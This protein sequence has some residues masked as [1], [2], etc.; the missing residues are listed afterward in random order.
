MPLKGK[1]YKMKERDLKKELK[2]A[3]KAKDA[4]K[5]DAIRMILGEVPRLNKKK[6]EV[7]TEEEITKITKALVKSEIIRLDAA[8]YTHGKSEYLTHLKSYLPEMMSE[9][10]IEAWILDN[11]DFDAYSNTM[12]AMG[13]IMK[14]LN[15]K[16]DGNLVR[17]ILTRS[18]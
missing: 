13:P 12:Q 15:G 16:A 1:G 18:T 5:K 14:G 6:G 7:V 10:E 3:I 2:S 11:I 17:Q 9:K 8:N 4:Y